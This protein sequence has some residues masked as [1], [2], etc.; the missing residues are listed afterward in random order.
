M[1][2]VCPVITKNLKSKYWKATAYSVWVRTKTQ[3]QAISFST[4]SVFKTNE[5]VLSQT[6][7]FMLNFFRITI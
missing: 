1:F 6:A 3:R 5:A 4:T 2:A 7:A